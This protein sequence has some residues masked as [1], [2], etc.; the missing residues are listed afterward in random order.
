VAGSHYDWRAS[1]I[2]LLDGQLVTHFGVWDYQMR[3]GTAR[4]RTGGIGAVATH[5]DFRKRGLMDRTARACV[6]AM[7]EL[8]Y[9]FSMLF[10]IDN[11]YHRFGY[12]RAWIESDYHLRVGD[13]PKQPPTRPLRKFRLRPRADLAELFNRCHAGVTGTAVRPTYTRRWYGSGVKNDQ[14]FLWLGAGRKPAGYVIVRDRGAH[15]DVSEAVGDPEQVLR[16]V[17][18]LARRFGV[19]EV[20]FN[21]LPYT[22]PLARRLRAGTCALA[23]RFQRCGGAMLRLINLPQALRKMSGELTRRLRASP[24][25]GWRGQLVVSDAEDAVVLAVSGGRVAVL[26]Y[27]PRGRPTYGIYGGDEMAQ[28]L[29]GTTDPFEIAAG[30]QTRITGDARRLLPFLFPD[31]HPLLH[32]ADRY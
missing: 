7:R 17:G 25:A 6:A 21:M 15:L 26:P 4:V 22:T 11:F 27:V 2:G 28:L 16:A 24:L 18:A 1:R 14:G 10:G 3:I 9:D 19:E 32:L 8:G 12:T 31:Q 23:C 30:H 5:G 13:L 20:H 29:L